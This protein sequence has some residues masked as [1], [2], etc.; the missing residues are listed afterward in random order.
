MAEGLI[1][2]EQEI[3]KL[4]APQVAENFDE[5]YEVYSA[6][7]V[8]Q[9]VDAMSKRIAELEKGILDTVTMPKEAYDLIIKQYKEMEHKLYSKPIKM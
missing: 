3:P 8:E 6:Y 7:K 4:G 5:Q 9:T 1:M 2:T